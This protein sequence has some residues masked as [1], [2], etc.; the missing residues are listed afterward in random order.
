VN[1]KAIRV[2]KHT[3]AAL[4]DN[5]VDNFRTVEVDSGQVFVGCV[6]PIDADTVKVETGQRG[7]PLVVSVDDIVEM[8]PVTKKNPHVAR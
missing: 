4:N 2:S 5:R 8:L 6:I 7:R 3:L 1:K